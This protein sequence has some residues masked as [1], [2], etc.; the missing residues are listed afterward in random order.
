MT[1]CRKHQVK[2]QFFNDSFYFECPSLR[3]KK[4]NNKNETKK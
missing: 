4:R 1:R 2:V 3:T